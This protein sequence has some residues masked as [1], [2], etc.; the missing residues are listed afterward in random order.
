[1]N[2]IKNE[3]VFII[4]SLE[5]GGA[6]RVVATQANMFKQQG[7]SVTIILF[8]N[9]VAYD[10]KKD[11]KIVYLWNKSDL[12]KAEKLCLIPIFVCKLNHLLRDIQKSQNIVLI[13]VHLP[14][15]HLICRLLKAKKDILF[16]LHNPHYQFKYS[17]MKIFHQAL[18]WMYDEKK[19]VTVSNGVKTELLKDFH[20]KSKFIKTIYNPID[21]INDTTSLKS[22]SEKEISFYKN[23]IL[24][25]GRLTKQKRPDKIIE[26]FYK[27]KYYQKYKLVILGV[28]ELYNSLLQQIKGY[29]LEKYIF[30]K[31]WKNNVYEWMENASLLVCT[32]DYESFGMVLAEALFFN[33]PVVSVNCDYGPSE[34]LTKELSVYLAEKNISSI[35]ETIDRALEYYPSDLKKYVLKF[36]ADLNIKTYLEIYKAWRNDYNK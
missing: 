7:Y 12:R 29:G 4:N 36:S 32:S 19:L 9:K 22:N 5:N 35:I 27:G 6:E 14:Y 23:Y 1:M 3:V 26:V 33:C 11:I 20:V 15:S 25:C 30:L 31:G 8:K 10:L 18:R 2:S 13:T 34:I 17:K 21:I 24:F 16:V 28:G